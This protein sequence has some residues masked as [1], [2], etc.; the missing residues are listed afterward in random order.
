M[1]RRKKLIIC[2]KPT[3]GH[4]MLQLSNCQRNL[5]KFCRTS[6]TAELEGFEQDETGT[7]GAAKS[8]FK[9]MDCPYPDQ[10]KSAPPLGK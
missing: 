9:I 2:T 8:W 6:S 4:R 3:T 7:T 1:P 10:Q 5:L